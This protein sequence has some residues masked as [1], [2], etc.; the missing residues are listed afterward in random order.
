MILTLTYLN[1]NWNKPWEEACV[2]QKTDWVQLVQVP[3]LSPDAGISA[4]ANDS[5][6]SSGKTTGQGFVETIVAEIWLCP[7]LSH[8]IYRLFKIILSTY[9][10]AK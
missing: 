1:L 8:N 10:Y 2:W 6:D 5:W 9:E 7:W 3:L 4:P